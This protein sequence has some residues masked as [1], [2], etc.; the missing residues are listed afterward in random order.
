MNLGATWE[1]GMNAPWFPRLGLASV[2]IGTTIYILGGYQWSSDSY[3]NDI[4]KSTNLGE[5][6]SS[7]GTGSW[8]A[9]YSHECVA[10][11]SSIILMGGY[12][13][14]GG[15]L[16]KNLNTFFFSDYFFLNIR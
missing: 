13:S 1:L 2:S 10:V 11:G 16:N 3:F 15:F 4:W 6:W 7:V 5:G 8:S 14:S 12:S 9:R